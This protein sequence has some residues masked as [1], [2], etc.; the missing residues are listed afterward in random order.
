MPEM[1]SFA[2]LEAFK[3]RSTDHYLP[4]IV[5]TAEPAHKLQAGARDLVSKLFELMEAA[6]RIQ[7]ILEARLPYQKL[8]LYNEALEA[9]VAI[10]ISQLSA[11]E[12]C[13]Q[14]FAELASDWYWEQNEAGEFTTLSGPM[15][16]MMGLRLAAL[17]GGNEAA[18]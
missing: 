8:R 17:S 6:T 18:Q 2:V 16:E 10:R 9:M 3:E 4:V 14:S 7:N 11:S 1:S 5:L 13:F 12:A 15:A